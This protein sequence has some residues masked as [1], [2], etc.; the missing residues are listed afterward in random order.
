MND[1]LLN[2][3]RHDYGD[4]ITKI[5]TWPPEL[6]IDVHIIGGAIIQYHPGGQK[7]EVDQPTGR[8]KARRRA[9]AARG[10]I[11]RLVSRS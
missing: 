3:A 4:L 9:A 5:I 1:E 10:A 2:Q 11:R 6:G 8:T 7:Y